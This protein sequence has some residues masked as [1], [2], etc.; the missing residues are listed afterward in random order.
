MFNFFFLFFFWFQGQRKPKEHTSS[1][2]TSC[3]GRAWRCCGVVLSTSALKVVEISICGGFLGLFFAGG[4]GGSGFFGR[5]LCL[6]LDSFFVCC[7]IG[8]SGRVCGAARLV[9]QSAMPA[10]KSRSCSLSFCCH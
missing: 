10:G 8:F 9:N 7:R 2:I 3:P 6:C 1:A 5:C 4:R